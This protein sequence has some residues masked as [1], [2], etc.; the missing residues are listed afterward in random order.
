MT[1][2]KRAL[3]GGLGAVLPIAVTLLTMEGVLI[4]EFCQDLVVHWHDSQEFWLRLA[5]LAGAVVQLVLLFALGA[6]VVAAQQSI[7]EWFKAVQLGVAAPALV[8]SYLHGANVDNGS[9]AGEARIVPQ[10]AAGEIVVGQAAVP[11]MLDMA[12]VYRTTQAQ[13]RP[14]ARPKPL[15]CFISGLRGRRC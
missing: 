14:P 1:T 5:S 8:M 3:F 13:T 2:W 6:G 12:F 9:R 7:T 4:A 15:D 11:A 10:A